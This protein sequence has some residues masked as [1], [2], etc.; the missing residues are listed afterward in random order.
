MIEGPRE[1]RYGQLFRRSATRAARLGL[2]RPDA[3]QFRG[4]GWVLSSSDSK[5]VQVEMKLKQLDM[6]LGD[7]LNQI[8]EEVGCSDLINHSSRL[9]EGWDSEL[10][11][12]FAWMSLATQ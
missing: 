10:L 7:G 3:G 6:V 11:L 2:S 4:L 12:L 9:G 5:G 1:V 8:G